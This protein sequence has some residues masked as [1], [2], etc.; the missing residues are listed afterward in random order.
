[1]NDY[2]PKTYWNTK[3]KNAKGNHI[4]ASC[5]SNEHENECMHQAQLHALN[6]VTDQ[7]VDINNKTI[8]D[9]GC[10]SGRWVEY[11]C[12]LGAS[13]IGVDI[14]DEMINLAK[15]RYPENS[16]TVLK[17]YKIPLEDDSCDFIFSIAVIHHNPPPQQEKLLSEISRVLKPGGYLFLFE[18]LGTYKSERVFPHPM[19]K[20]IKMVEENNFKCILQ[21]GYS[22]F[23][24]CNMVNNVA[25]LLHI[26]R[27]YRW[28]PWRPKFLLKLDAKVS[29]GLSHRLPGKYHDR[30]AMLFKHQE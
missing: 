2:N 13:Y 21:Q 15:S 22:Y 19:S 27:A 9:F 18:A 24:L 28:Y 12:N 26:P 8:L 25:K 14:S 17:D 1:M 29:P 3:A 6:A 30:G 23:V 16:F 4:H 7:L 10:G 20:W 11:F 5:G